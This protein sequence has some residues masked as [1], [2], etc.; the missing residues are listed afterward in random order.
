[1]ALPLSIVPQ[2]PKE[3]TRTETVELLRRWLE[4]AESG[5]LIEVAL[6]GVERDGAT[7]STRSTSGDISRLLGGVARLAYRINREMD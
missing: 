3:T 1:M 7:M 4:M 5:S 6:V 2:L